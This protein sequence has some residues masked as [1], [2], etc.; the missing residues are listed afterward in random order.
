MAVDKNLLLYGDNLEMLRRH[1]PDASVDLVYLDPPFN[2]NKSYNV[3]FQSRSGDAA[4]A[5]IE[6]FDDTWTW[7]QETEEQFQKLIE[8]DAPPAVA[9][10]V[11]AM[12][13]LLGDNDVL[14]YLIMMTPRLLELHRV[15]KSTGSLYLHADPTASHYLKL[16]LDAVFGPRNFRNEIIWKRYGAHNDQG[17]GSKHYGRVHDVILFYG[18]SPDLYWD[19]QYTPLDESYVESTYRGVEPET[20]RRFMTTPMTGPGGAAKG[21]PVF[22]WKGHTRAWRYN[23]E[24]ME[25]LDAEGR[26]YYSKTGYARQKFYLDESKGVPLQ[27]LWTDIKSLV[28]INKER[29]GFPTQKPVALL[30][31]IIESSCPEGG[32][33]LDPFCGCGTTVTAAQNLNRSWI[34][35]DITFLSIDLIEKRLVDAHGEEVRHTYETRGIPR[36]FEGARALFSSSPFDFER[37]AV[38][39]VNGQPNQKQVGDKGMDGVI[40]FPLDRKKEVGRALVSVKGGQQLNPAM[41]RDLIGT[42]DS[43]KAEM[44]V[45]VTMQNPTKGMV[46]AAHHSDTYEW[47]FNG[48]KFPKVQVISV[49]QLL[50]GEKPQMP[51]TFLPYMKARREVFDDQQMSFGEES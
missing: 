30:E 40:R 7:S 25:R 22:D 13:R 45:L 6:A 28:G 41:V 20:G 49:G 4:Q 27:D 48:T 47:P 37:W 32:V 9:D 14:A 50:R 11:E 17:Q 44:G 2:S 24:T 5:Q 3:L 38:S 31:R 23:Y 43:Q 29:L 51:P 34:G 35:I 36:D 39:L 21:N 16:I 33:V 42:V 15:L 10:A 19:Q 18:K 1:V 26:I 46:D 12:R 8:G